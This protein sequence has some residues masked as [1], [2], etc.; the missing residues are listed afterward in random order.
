[1][2][3]FPSFAR[4]QGESNGGAP[5]K[6]GCQ[7]P[8]L[9]NSWRSHWH[10]GSGGET[11]GDF[12]FGV[13]QLSAVIVAANS[14]ANSSI[15]CTQIRWYQTRQL[16]SLPNPLM[17]NTFMATTY[18]LGDATSPYGS[19]HTRYKTEVGERLSLAGRHVAYGEHVYTGPVFAN[20][21]AKSCSA[22]PGGSSSYSITLGF[23]NPG[24]SGLEIRPM[25]IS[26]TFD[27]GRWTGSSAFEVCVLGA[28]GSGDG[29]PPQRQRQL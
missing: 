8:A 15:A 20:I 28:D 26:K 17:K 4:H 13:V 21:T 2:F 27:Q 16:G 10:S 11:A 3:A 24:A 19:V 18:D 22:S 23:R 9:V 12:P 29:S 25:N 5:V 1:M 6:Y 7:L 14:S